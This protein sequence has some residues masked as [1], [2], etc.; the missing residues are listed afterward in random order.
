MAYHFFST[1]KND[2]RILWDADE[3]DLLRKNADLHRF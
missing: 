2:V 1:K 3:T